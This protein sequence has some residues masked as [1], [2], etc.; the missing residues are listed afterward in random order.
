MKKIKAFTTLEISIVMLLTALL[1][2]IAY[3][4]YLYLIKQNILHN[5]INE[6]ALGL[7]NLLIRLKADTFYSTKM[8]RDK[9]SMLFM[10]PSKTIHYEFLD[11]Y[12]LRRQA[13]VCDTFHCQNQELIARKDHTSTNKLQDRIDSFAFTIQYK[14]EE[15]T[16]HFYKDYGN[17]MDVEEAIKLQLENDM[18]HGN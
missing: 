2:G 7:Q 17:I 12:V 3:N 6:E 15:N 18:I 10:Y 13:E 16:I 1:S 14:N 4:G 5:K 9:N 8:Y 11:N